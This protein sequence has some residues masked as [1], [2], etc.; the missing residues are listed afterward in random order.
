M[1][2]NPPS[3]RTNIS[4]AIEYLGQWLSGRGAVPINN[5]MEDAATA[6]ISRAQ[7]WQWIRHG[8][9]VELTDGGERRLTADWLGELV[10]AEIVTILDRL[11]PAGFHRGRYA[12][13]ARIVQE[14]QGYREQTVQ[15]AQ[16]QASRFDQVYAQYKNAPAVTRERIYIETMEKVLSD[17]DKVIPDNKQGV[18]PYLPLGGFAPQ[19]AGAKG[20]AQ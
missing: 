15:E 11:G 4:V 8:A 10:Q 14:A 13:A 5:L 9:A 6:E 2:A 20:A 12:S 7:L 18:L 19:A 3:A 17:T 16:G 1:A